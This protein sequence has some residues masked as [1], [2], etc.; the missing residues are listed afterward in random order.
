MRP[1]LLGLSSIL[2]FLLACGG[3]QKDP[4][5]SHTAGM[6]YWEIRELI[7]KNAEGKGIEHWINRPGIT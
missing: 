7:F 3:G 1:T 4:M 2:C 6:S 5:I